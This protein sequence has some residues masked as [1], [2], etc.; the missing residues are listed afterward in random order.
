MVN[1]GE[2]KQ[3]I[4]IAR[5]LDTDLG[6]LE[7]FVPADGDFTISVPNPIGGM[8]ELSISGADKTTVENRASG[9]F[10]D[11][12]NLVSGLSWP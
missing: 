8:G 11:L 9:L 3:V 6:L 5:G 10:V 2:T 7:R 12:Q 1:S 4:R